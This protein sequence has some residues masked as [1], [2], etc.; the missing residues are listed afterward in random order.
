MQGR[1]TET[2]NDDYES[3][4]SLEVIYDAD[5]KKSNWLMSVIA[6][7]PSFAAFYEWKSSA[8]RGRWIIRRRLNCKEMF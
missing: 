4:L 3:E 6:L 2:L 5:S 1:E 8:G 7:S